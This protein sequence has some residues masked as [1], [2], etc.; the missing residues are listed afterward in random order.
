MAIL[1]TDNPF[2]DMDVAVDSLVARFAAQATNAAKG[3][4]AEARAIAQLQ[5]RLDGLYKKFLNFE[6]KVVADKAARID[7][8]FGEVFTVA[9]AAGITDL[10]AR[11]KSAILTQA[12]DATALILGFIQASALTFS[13]TTFTEAATNDGSILQSATITLTGDTFKGL[14]GSLLAEIND[15]PGGLTASITKTNATTAT[16]TFGGKAS[17]HASEDTVRNV[18]VD[19]SA[20]DFSSGSIAGKTGLSQALTFRFFDVIASESN[21]LLVLDATIEVDVVVNLLTNKLLFNGAENILS[22]GSMSSVI[23]V[24]ASGLIGEDVTVNIFGNA[25]ANIFWASNLDGSITGGDGNDTI[26]LGSGNYTVVGGDG[27]DTLDLSTG[28][29]T[30]SFAPTPAA[31][32]IDVISN[33]NV[34]GDSIDILDFSAFLGAAATRTPTRVVSASADITFV[35]GGLVIL[36]GNGLSTEAAI[37]AE[38][39][40]PII[41]GKMVI[42]SADVSGDATVWF[43]TNTGADPTQLLTSEISKVATLVGVNNLSLAGNQFTV[44]NFL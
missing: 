11:Y 18:V 44:D 10:H 1:T 35:N 26:Y 25:A 43:I 40:A 17:D 31:N 12:P 13:Q 16:L 42:I 27:N 32:D 5:N 9:K 20:A 33:F 23:R 29:S 39:A 34:V 30:V 8:G 37:L 36:D 22:G 7:L 6:R 41:N 14:N 15:L 38:F 2:I 21:G 28:V 24:D 4:Q 19:F 3:P